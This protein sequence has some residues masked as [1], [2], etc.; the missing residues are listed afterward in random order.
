MEALEDEV[1]PMTVRPHRIQ[2]KMPENITIYM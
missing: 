2:N 1:R